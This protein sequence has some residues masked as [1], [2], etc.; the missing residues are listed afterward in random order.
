[1][2]DIADDYIDDGV[3]LWNDHLAGHPQFPDICP[4]CEDET[5]PNCGKYICVCLDE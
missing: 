3:L 1:M 4:Y 2:G 5:C